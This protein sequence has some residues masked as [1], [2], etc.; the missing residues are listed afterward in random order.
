MFVLRHVIRIAKNN[1]RVSVFHSPP[2]QVYSHDDQHGTWDVVAA[3]FFLDTA[4]NILQY[5]EVISRCLKPGGL[6]ISLGE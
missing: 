4:H 5:L 6:L 2:S 3:S 1:P